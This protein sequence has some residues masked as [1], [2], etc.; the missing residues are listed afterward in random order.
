MRARPERWPRRTW[1]AGGA[2]AAVR[3]DRRH[4]GAASSRSSNSPFQGWFEVCRPIGQV[5]RGGLGAWRDG[6][7]PCCPLIPSRGVPPARSAW[8][9]CGAE[10]S[11]GRDFRPQQCEEPRRP[12]GGPTEGRPVFGTRSGP[13]HRERSQRTGPEE[14]RQ[15]PR[16]TRQA[17]GSIKSRAGEVM[18]EHHDDREAHR[19]CRAC[20]SRPAD[21]ATVCEHCRAV[22][23]LPESPGLVEDEGATVR[24]SFEHRNAEHRNG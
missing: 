7:G 14:S 3:S 6:R 15:A 23:D 18:T 8:G 13:V 22:L 1:S 24:R 12:D 16:G 17:H 10:E 19:V 4:R 21:N 9:T 20:G 5:T 11:G 2:T